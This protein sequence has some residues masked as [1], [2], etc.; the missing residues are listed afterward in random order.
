MSL[1]EET[2]LTGKDCLV[3]ATLLL[4]ADKPQEALDWIER[5]LDIDQQSSRGFMSRYELNELKREVLVKLGRREEVIDAVWLDYSRS[6]SIAGYNS[7]MTY[8]SEPDRAAWQERAIHTA[9]SAR[10]SSAMEILVETGESGRLAVIVKNS[11]AEVQSKIHH[12]SMIDR[13][14]HCA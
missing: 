4:K 3:I 12:K 11:S 10:L 2:G 9:M 7:L 6:P 8:V 5:G 1:A 14:L 13:R